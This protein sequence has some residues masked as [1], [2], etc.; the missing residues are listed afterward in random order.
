MA[1]GFINTYFSN[2][3]KKHWVLLLT[4]IV[5]GL[6]LYIFLYF[7]HYGEV[8]KLVEQPLAYIIT[9]VMSVIAAYVIGYSN[10]Q[11]DKLVPWKKQFVF[12]FILALLVGMIIV[13]S[14]S[15]LG[16]V[17]GSIFNKQLISLIINE[18]VNERIKMFILSFFVI[19]IYQVAYFSIYSYQQYAVVQLSKLR[20]NREQLRLQFDALKSQLSPHFLF[21]SLNTISSLL[22]KNPDSAEEFIRRLAT[23]YQYV[24]S[25]K[26]NQ[27]VS[28]AEEVEFIKSY[29]HLLKV[30]FED[31]LKLEINLPKNVLHTVIP[32]LTL[33]ILI[34]NA[35]KH[36]QIDEMNHL[37]IYI[38]SV[39]NTTLRITNNKGDKPPNVRSFKV[40]LDN[41]KKRYAY[42]SQ[43]AIKINDTKLFSV[44]LPVIPVKTAS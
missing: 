19:F 16:I 7:S 5:T 25:N 34:E 36:N 11:L 1:S 38:G 3:M 39:D 8:P 13:T 35:V 24:I 44:E 17:V 4:G 9:L 28:V 26:Q 32:P 2:S 10:T 31:S 23:T 42:Y 40:G 15:L 33:Q 12:R 43:R 30:R 41:I 20:E 22:H 27:L 6:F 18:F 21:N 37:E 29:Y 14:I